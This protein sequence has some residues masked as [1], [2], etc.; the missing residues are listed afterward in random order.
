MKARDIDLFFTELN[1]RIAFRVRVLLTGGAAGVLQGIHRA[2]HDID[3]EI[4]LMLRRSTSD[5]WDSLRRAIEETGR[6]TGITPQ[7][8][9]DIDRWS[10]ISLPSKKSQLY[11][12]IGRVEIRILDPSLWAIGKLTRFLSTDISDVRTVLRAKKPSPVSTVRLWGTAL[13]QSPL[14][15]AHSQFRRQVELF[16]ETHGR[17]IWGSKTDLSRLKDAFLRAAQRARQRR[18]RSFHA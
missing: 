15:S 16:L 12:R 14:S 4:H 11:R 10:S 13:G 3:F 5:A 17:E 9:E 2:T 7:Y 1:R 18:A 6:S 8:A